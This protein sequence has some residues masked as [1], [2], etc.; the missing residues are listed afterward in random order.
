[1]TL[2][3]AVAKCVWTLGRVLSIPAWP[4]FAIADRISSARGEQWTG[5]KPG[6][7]RFTALVL[8]AVGLLL[9]GIGFLLMHAAE[10][11]AEDID[12]PF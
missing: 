5:G 12:K 6:R 11:I 3:F 9:G 1:M 10:R 7:L 4:V 2:R 8:E